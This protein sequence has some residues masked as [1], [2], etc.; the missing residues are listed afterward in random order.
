MLRQLVLA[1]GLVFA[2]MASAQPSS[3]TEPFPPHRIAGNLF[4]VGSRDLASYLITTP[5]G[6]ILINSSLEESVPLIRSSVEKLG[7]K[8]TDIRI[9][10]IS[11]AH[12]DHCAGSEEILKLTGAKHFVMEGDADAVENGG[13]RKARVGK[14]DYTQFPPAKVDRRLKDGDEVKLGNTVLVAH[15]TPGHTPGCTTWTMKVDGLNAVIIGSPNV[16][17]GYVLVGNKNYPAIATDYERTFRVL[18]SLPVDLFLGAHGGYYDMEAKH[19]LFLVAGG[20]N[21][22]VDPEGYL[23]YV[24]DREAAFRKEWEKQKG[25]K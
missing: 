17:P 9:L 20:N 14:G 8:F 24:N 3:W 22:F 25:A 18:K 12:S 5:E 13:A 4:Y 19:R 16:N 23:R 21:P 15:L 1:L 6:H 2:S 10:L 11:H 7:F